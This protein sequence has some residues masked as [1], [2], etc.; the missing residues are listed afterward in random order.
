MRKVEI[1][2]GR[3]DVEVVHRD[4]ERD[5][6]M[7]PEEARAY[8]LIDE[9]IRGTRGAGAVATPSDGR[10]IPLKPAR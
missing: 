8:G 3:K 5:Y 7:D 6:F 4:T 9:I 2:I 1:S 10:T